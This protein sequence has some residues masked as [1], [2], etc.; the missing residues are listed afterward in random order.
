MF[1]LVPRRK[2]G[3]VSPF[4]SNGDPF[5]NLFENFFSD[6]PV[7]ESHNWPQYWGLDANENEKEVFVRAELPGFD[8][9]ELDVQLKNNV[10]T[11]EARHG[12]EGKDGFRHVRRVLTL[13]EGLDVEK[14]EASYKNGVLDLRIPRLP[15]TTARKIEVKA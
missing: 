6:F 7:F 11:L 13:P 2:V 4:Q 10:L 15:E 12:E 8:V 5:R 3:P 9:N 1:S 14:I